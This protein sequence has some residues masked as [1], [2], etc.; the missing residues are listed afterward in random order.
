[1][2][3]EDPIERWVRQDG[4][5]CTDL[6]CLT[7]GKKKTTMTIDISEKREEE[8]NICGITEIDYTYC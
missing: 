6:D 7:T 8:K 3:Y 5:D 2:K 1:M 4:F